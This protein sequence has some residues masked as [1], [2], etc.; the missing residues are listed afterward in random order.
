MKP[1]RN[2]SM[3]EKLLLPLGLVFAALV[4]VAGTLRWSL[5]LTYALTAL[6]FAAVFGAR[7]VER[8]DRRR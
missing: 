1:D 3:L 8:R 5:V 4:I 7:H 2:H 6:M